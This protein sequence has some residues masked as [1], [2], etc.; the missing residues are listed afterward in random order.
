[1]IKSDTPALHR[2]QQLLEAHNCVSRLR[3]EVRLL[4]Q[5]GRLRCVEC[6][7]EVA[8]AHDAIWMTD[9][10]IGSMFVNAHGWVNESCHDVAPC[11][12]LMWHHAVSPC[13]ATSVSLLWHHAVSLLWQC[14]K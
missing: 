3:A 10:G 14:S 4:S 5:L 8:A 1:M 2:R 6:G 12:A 7:S 13:G 9:E 11:C